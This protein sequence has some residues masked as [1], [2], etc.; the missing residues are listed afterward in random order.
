MSENVKY[1]TQEACEEYRKEIHSKLSNHD[2]RLIVLETEIKTII[3]LS[4]MIFA[5]VLASGGTIL[6]AILLK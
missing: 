6:V 1:V 3:G 2:S 5:A 4:K